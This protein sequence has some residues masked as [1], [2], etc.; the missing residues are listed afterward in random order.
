MTVLE[1]V[2]LR[3]LMDRSILLQKV[4]NN[5]AT[6]RLQLFC[7]RDGDGFIYPV[8]PS[9]PPYHNIH[10][11]LR[12][13]AVCVWYIEWGGSGK[14]VPPQPPPFKRSL[15]HHLKSVLNSRCSI[16]AMFGTSFLPTTSRRPT[17]SRSTFWHMNSQCRLLI[18]CPNHKLS[19]SLNNYR[20][21]KEKQCTETHVWD[22]GSDCV[23]NFVKGI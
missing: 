19:H 14:P 17:L 18:G 4:W 7:V 2:Q 9:V 1:N 21:W 16:T 11:T 22:S 6:N 5:S 20:Y 12:C 8:R 23:H 3:S 15:T 10:T 13:N